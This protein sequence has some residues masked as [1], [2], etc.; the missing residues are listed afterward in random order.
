MDGETLDVKNGSDQRRLP[1]LKWLDGSF[2]PLLCANQGKAWLAVRLN[3]P[4]L[5]RFKSK[6]SK[7]SKLCVL[8]YAYKVYFVDWF[9]KYITQ[10]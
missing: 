3:L 10:L 1:M 2:Y 5:L 6:G 9:N 4:I 8:Y 7:E